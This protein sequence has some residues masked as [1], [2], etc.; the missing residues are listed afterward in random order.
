MGVPSPPVHLH[1]P[2]TLAV[3]DLQG[4][5]LGNGHGLV[6]APAIYYD[7]FIPRGQGYALESRREMVLFIESRHNHRDAG[8][9]RRHDYGARTGHCVTYPGAATTQDLYD[10]ENAQ[11]SDREAT[12]CV[13]DGG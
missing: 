7:Q 8:R 13:H 6:S 9:G 11:R 5:L 10:A 2:P 12:A 3:Q 4:E 1:R